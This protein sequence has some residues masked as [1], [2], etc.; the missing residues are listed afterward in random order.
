MSTNIDI[1]KTSENIYEDGGISIDP[2]QIIF[3]NRFLF[4]MIISCVFGFYCFIYADN[5]THHYEVYKNTYYFLSSLLLL[6]QLYLFFR[7][8]SHLLVPNHNYIDEC[9]ICSNE[10]QSHTV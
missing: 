4:L 5:L 3:K 8:Y 9:E 1:K 6:P 10:T 7:L 2:F